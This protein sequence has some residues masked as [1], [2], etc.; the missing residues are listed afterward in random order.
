MGRTS[1]AL[2][3]EH[4]G[5]GELEEEEGG[6]DLVEDAVPQDAAGLVLRAID[7]DDVVS[8]SWRDEHRRD[9]SVPEAEVCR[10]VGKRERVQR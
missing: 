4:A 10:H 9:Q 1:V 6:H 8:V 5:H 7:V 3:A 2:G